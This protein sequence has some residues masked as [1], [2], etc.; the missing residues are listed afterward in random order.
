MLDLFSGWTWEEIVRI[1]ELFFMGSM[2]LAAVFMAGLL[3]I[4]GS[5]ENQ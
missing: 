4:S 3:N 1:N 2:I 5:G